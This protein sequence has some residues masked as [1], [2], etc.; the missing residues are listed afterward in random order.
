MSTAKVFSIISLAC[1]SVLLLLSVSE[2]W[3]HNPD[4]G[5]YVGTAFNILKF[6]EY[7]FN[8]LPNLQYYPGFSTLLTIPISLF[9]M[10]FYFLN[11]FSTLIAISVLWMISLYFNI[12]RYGPIIILIPLIFLSGAIFQQQIIYIR[13]GAPFLLLVLFSLFFWRSYL[14]TGSKKTLLACLFFVA[15]SPL[16][17]FEGLFL[18]LSFSLAYLYYQY[19]KEKQIVSSIL[20]TGLISI[21]I[22]LPFALWTYRNF[23]LHTPDTINMANQFFFGL[24]GQRFYAPDYFKVD[25]INSGS[26]KYGAYHLYQ[27]IR[28]IS[29]SFIGNTIDLTKFSGELFRLFFLLTVGFF[30]LYGLKE[31]FKKATILEISFVILLTLY[32]VNRSLSSNN[33]YTVTRYWLPL[34]PFYIAFVLIGYRQIID[35]Q[36]NKYLILFIRLSSLTLLSVIF[37]NGIIVFSSIKNNDKKEEYYNQA[38]LSLQSMSDYFKNNTAN[39]TTIAT[40][41]FGVLPL[42]IKRKSF[43]LINDDNYNY[44]YS[45]KIIQKYHTKYLAILDE[46]AAIWPSSR[47]MVIM[48]PDIFQLVRHFNPENKIGPAA[49]IYKID[50]KRVDSEIVVQK[51]IIQQKK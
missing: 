9:G 29:Y 46:N 49:S 7:T 10:D 16:F 36:K 15:I 4:S 20:S 25:W 26:W 27:T 42:Y 1:L 31:W 18:I 6:G 33:L 50:L 28:D 39:D 24:K 22:F 8:S 37:I 41:D 51:E 48:Y 3:Y 13:T 11:L 2:Y 47:A 32:F 38:T 12:S 34:L 23:Q 21:I 45:L 40:T 35:N 43:R 44:L 14:N 19:S 17:R 5:I 30:A